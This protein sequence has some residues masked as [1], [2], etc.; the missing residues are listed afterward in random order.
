MT[1]HG[2]H[3][4]VSGVLCEQRRDEKLSEPVEGSF[5]VFGRHIEVVVGVVVG[6][7]GVVGSVVVGQILGVLVFVWILL[8]AQE[9]HVLKKVSKSCNP[10]VSSLFFFS[11][12]GKIVA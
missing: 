3:F 7:V 9:K 10:Q 1:T 2:F 11:L 5:E 4:S 6:R 12:Y 8:R